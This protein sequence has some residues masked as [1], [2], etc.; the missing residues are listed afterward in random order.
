MKDLFLVLLVTF[1]TC[2]N[3]QSQVNQPTVQK[4]AITSLL[5]PKIYLLFDEKENHRYFVRV[6]E[7][8]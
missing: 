3:T 7:R 4:L 1:Y 6:R 8:R 5:R 2:S